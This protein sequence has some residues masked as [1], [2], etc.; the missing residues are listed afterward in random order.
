MLTLKKTWSQ[1]LVHGY[2]YT[3]LIDDLER[4]IIQIVFSEAFHPLGIFQDKHFEELNLLYFYGYSQL[5][6]ILNSLSYQ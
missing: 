4:N 3:H 6:D 2:V 5:E 1:S